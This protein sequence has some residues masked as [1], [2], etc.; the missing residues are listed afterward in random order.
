[1]K[2]CTCNSNAYHSFYEKK[3]KFY[4]WRCSAYVD[5]ENIAE[6]MDADLS[7][8]RPLEIPDELRPLEQADIIWPNITLELARSAGWYISEIKG[9]EC[10]VLPVFRYGKMVF[11]TARNLEYKND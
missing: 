1:M 5:S 2:L 4:C 8:Y 11:Y 3:Q 6:H 10:L 7:V 9:F